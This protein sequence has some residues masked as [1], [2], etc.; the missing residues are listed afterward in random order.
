MLDER[1]EHV[2]GGD[3]A[4]RRISVAAVATRID[5]GGEGCWR[6]LRRRDERAVVVDEGANMK[7]IVLGDAEAT[8]KLSLQQQCSS[9]SAVQ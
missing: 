1:T 4:T 8:L 9:A 6:S 2:G 5:G 7:A 3:H